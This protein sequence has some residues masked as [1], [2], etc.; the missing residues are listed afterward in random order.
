MKPLNDHAFSGFQPLFN[1]PVASLPTG[2]VH[3]TDL[4][5]VIRADHI[6]KGSF[7]ALLD[8]G[9]EIVDLPEPSARFHMVESFTDLC[10]MF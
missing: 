8:A 10:R 7:R 3:F 1:Q 9:F 6:D 5:L 2:G 4:D